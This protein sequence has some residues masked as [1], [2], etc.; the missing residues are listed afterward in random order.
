MG[1]VGAKAL[2]CIHWDMGCS[3][4]YYI[5]YSRGYFMLYN[6]VKCIDGSDYHS[7]LSSTSHFTFADPS[8]KPA[9]CNLKPET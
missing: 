6:I 1:W 7:P 9:T 8:L 4:C 5:G 2:S 3:L